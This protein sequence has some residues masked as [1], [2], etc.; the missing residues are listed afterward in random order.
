ME[1]TRRIAVVWALAICCVRPQVACG[2]DLP[3]ETHASTAWKA[4][5]AEADITPKPD[6][7][8]M[9][10]GF[11]KPRMM[12]GIESPL[13]AQALPG[14]RKCLNAARPAYELVGDVDDLQARFPDAAH[15][16]PNAE[17]KAA[18]DFLDQHLGDQTN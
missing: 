1:K 13:R 18:Y 10:A 12:D 4:G 17:R 9:A 14:V 15:D 16:F 8:I 2:D 7:P 3:A 6:K 11:G 5:Y